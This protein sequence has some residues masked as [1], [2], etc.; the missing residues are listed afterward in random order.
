MNIIERG[1]GGFMEERFIKDRFFIE[2]TEEEEKKDILRN[3]FHTK[4]ELTNA[5]KNFEFANNNELIDYYVYKIKSMQAQ[6]D[7]LIKLAKEKGIEV[8]KLA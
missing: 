8:E 4:A 3:I 2:M 7:R 5:N 1:R 6:L